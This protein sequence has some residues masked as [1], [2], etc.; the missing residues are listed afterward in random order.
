M[1][2]TNDNGG[3]LFHLVDLPAPAVRAVG[4][5]FKAHQ[6]RLFFN[7]REIAQCFH[8]FDSEHTKI[9]TTAVQIAETLALT[10]NAAMGKATTSVANLNDAALG[11]LA[12][13]NDIVSQELELMIPMRPAHWTPQ[14]WG[15]FQR[16]LTAARDAIAKAVANG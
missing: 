1:Q 4:A 16:S 9:T 2:N 10:L 14:E 5:S 11:M 12:A 8:Q 6:G 3:P 7:G 15:R 13:L